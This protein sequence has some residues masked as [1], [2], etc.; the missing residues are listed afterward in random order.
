MPWNG[1]QYHKID[2]TIFVYFIL[3]SRDSIRPMSDHHNI[4]MTTFCLFVLFLFVNV[5]FLFESIS[6]AL[7]RN[8]F[9]YTN[10]QVKRKTRHSRQ[11]SKCKHGNMSSRYEEFKWY[12]KWFSILNGERIQYFYTFSFCSTSKQ[13]NFFDANHGA[14]EMSCTQLKV[15]Y[16]RL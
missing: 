5:F 4:V 12:G 13:F 9:I 8:A 14:N 3:P 15:A 6:N 1:M 10:K 11:I 2:T 7:L 16:T